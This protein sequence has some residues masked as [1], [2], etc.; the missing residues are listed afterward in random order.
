MRR[1]APHW[2]LL[3]VGV[4]VGLA[5]S[6]MALLGQLHEREQVRQAHEQG[7]ADWVSLQDQL[8]RFEARWQTQ[9]RQ[10]PPEPLLPPPPEPSLSAAAFRE[11]IEQSLALNGLRDAP[12]ATTDQ[13]VLRLSVQ[14]A[15]EPV[16]ALIVQ[17]HEASVHARLSAWSVHCT[18]PACEGPMAWQLSWQL[19]G[20]PESPSPASSAPADAPA[21][22]A[23]F[24]E[25]QASASSGALH[26]PFMTQAWWQQAVD[27]APMAK[28]TSRRQWQKDMQ[29]GQH[30]THEHTGP[31]QWLGWMGRREGRRAW[32]QAGG[33][34]LSVQVGQAIAKEP[35]V[36]EAMDAQGL[37]L[38]RW[39]LNA[40]GRWEAKREFLDWIAAE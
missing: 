35:V 38:R 33:E 25:V 32:V 36:V 39:G 1:P 5:C 20:S 4:G 22:P 15:L 2:M 34:T 21:T 29:A 14:A 16:L 12:L 6:G 31:W 30:V 18:D 23:A 3:A 8:R 17:V 11:L 7:Q 27:Q 9:M 40:Q 13:G 28:G 26:N 10:D 24:A 19:M 37:R